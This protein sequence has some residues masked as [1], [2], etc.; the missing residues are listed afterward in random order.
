MH[1]VGIN[2]DMGDTDHPLVNSEHRQLL[3]LYNII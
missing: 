1:T 3:E 2:H